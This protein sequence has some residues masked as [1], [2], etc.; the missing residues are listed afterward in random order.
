[1][2]LVLALALGVGVVVTMSAVAVVMALVLVGSVRSVMVPRL[3][4]RRNREQDR[5]R[6]DQGS[7]VC[8][9]RRRSEQATCRG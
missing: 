8:P 3:G 1:M 2:A 9:S 5:Q 7:H 4:Q 6:Y